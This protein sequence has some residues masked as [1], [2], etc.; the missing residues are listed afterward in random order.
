LEASLEATLVVIANMEV[1]SAT[2]LD[3]AS[4]PEMMSTDL[5]EYLVRQGVPFRKAHDTLSEVIKYSRENGKKLSALTLDEMKRFA[6][7][8]KAD[9]FALY[10]A[11][12]SADEKTSHGGTS[13]ANVT[14][15][16]ETHRRN[17]K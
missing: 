8:F 11:R 12:K 16:M 9:V 15:A 1:K 3:A 2:T 10:D 14:K 6:P 4:D 13:T 7:E 17:L 5:V